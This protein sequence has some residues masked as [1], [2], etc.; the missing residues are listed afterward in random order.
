MELRE[1]VLNRRSIRKYEKKKVEDDKI[2]S[3]LQAAMY[4]P[5]ARNYQPWHF[6]VINDREILDRVPAVHPYADM[7]YGAPM[8]ILVCGDRNLEPMDEYL[9]I[10]CAAAT[11]NMLLTA[12]DQGLGAVWLGVYPRK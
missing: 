11:Q 12:H 8:A 7:I 1:A 4:S 6:I 2:K 9:A 5:S 10:N 3:I